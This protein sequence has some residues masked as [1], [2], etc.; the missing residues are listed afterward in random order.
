MRRD[1]SGEV[2]VER[3]PADLLRDRAAD[4]VNDDIP[5][6][7][8]I[9]ER[10]EAV[11]ALDLGGIPGLSALDRPGAARQGPVHGR[12]PETE[13]ERPIRRT[14]VVDA[15][16]FIDDPRSGREAQHECEHRPRALL[17]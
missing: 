7:A 5:V 3:L 9:I 12:V 10:D 4:R 8:K 16:E 1:K 14:A 17:P 2:A 6:P 15:D 13:I 11:P